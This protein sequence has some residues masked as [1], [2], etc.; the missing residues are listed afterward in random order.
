MTGIGSTHHVLGVPHLL[1]ELGDSESTVLLR[2]AGGERSEADHEEVKARKRN[3][4]DGE[5]S[6]VRVELSGESETASDTTH[7]SR[8]QMV[9]IA[10]CNL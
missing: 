7:G 2:P 6:E 5:L 4:I 9:Q 10:D 1:G 3:E 8:N